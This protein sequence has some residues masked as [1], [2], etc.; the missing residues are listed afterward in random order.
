M[1]EPA[2]VRGRSCIEH[3]DSGAHYDASLPL[4]RT[5]IGGEAGE[6]H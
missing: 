1:P 5:R 4:N 2:E 6:R 3:I